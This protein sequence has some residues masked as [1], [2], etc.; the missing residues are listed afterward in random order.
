MTL[1][2]QQM[3]T[4]LGTLFLGKAVKDKAIKAA[5]SPEV[6]GCLADEV[7][8]KSVL[9]QFIVFVKY[10]H[11]SG[12]PQTDFLHTEHMTDAAT[13]QELAK[14][15]KKIVRLPAGT[16]EDEKLCYR[17]SRSN[18]WQAQWIGGN[19]KKRSARSN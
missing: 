6:F 17:F 11:A 18:D 14:C 16:E 12:F 8:D 5:A 10:V 19:H 2:V 7:T 9:Q 3:V 1:Q 15:L 4:V 13:G